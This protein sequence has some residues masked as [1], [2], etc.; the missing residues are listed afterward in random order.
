MVGHVVH[1]PAELDEVLVVD[2]RMTWTGALPTAG[3][4]QQAASDDQTA[5]PIHPYL[6]SPTK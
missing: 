4:E 3:S 6:D 1:G 2:H 5:K